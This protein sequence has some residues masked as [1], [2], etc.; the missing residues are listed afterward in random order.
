MTY[1]LLA[2]LETRAYNPVP[3]ALTS[4]L[5]LLEFNNY[6]LLYLSVVGP[7]QDEVNSLRGLGNSILNGHTAIARNIIVIERRGD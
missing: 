7:G 6:K 3:I 1:R 4:A 2:V 5:P